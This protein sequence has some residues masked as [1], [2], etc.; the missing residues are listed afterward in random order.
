[1]TNYYDTYDAAQTVYRFMYNCMFNKGSAEYVWFSERSAEG[2][3]LS[4]DTNIEKLMVEYVMWG[5]RRF[6]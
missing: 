2:K 1:M 4:E 5:A 6:L 3:K